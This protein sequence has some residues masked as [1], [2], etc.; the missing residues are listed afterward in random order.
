MRNLYK[1]LVEKPERR[2]PVGRP[3]CIWKDTNKMSL[4]GRVCEDVNCINS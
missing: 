1:I 4:K 2:R 3:R